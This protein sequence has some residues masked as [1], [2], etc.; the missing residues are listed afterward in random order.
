MAM[1]TRKL[2]SLFLLC[3]LTIACEDSIDHP[4]N[5]AETDLLVVEGTLTNENISHSVKLSMPY[6]VQNGSPSPVSGALIKITEGSTVYPLSESPVGSGEYYTPPFRAITGK[7]YTLTIQYQGKQ[8]FA[9]DSAM[10]VEALFPL[11]YHKVN[12]K[13]SLTLN[14]SGQESNFIEHEIQWKNTS[15]CTSGESCEGKVVYYDLKTIDVNEIF[16]P[17][18]TDFSFPLNTVIIRRKFSVSPTYKAFLRSMLSETEWRG[19]I[20]DIQR[21]DVATNLSEGAIGFFAVSTVVSDTTRI[22]EKP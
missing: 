6:R 20:F 1:K 8:F 5:S 22:I 12:D 17:G 7:I 4:L 13:F 14:P 15:A 16:K 19:G 21:A 9:H 11:D 3:V 2:F 10:P 18:K